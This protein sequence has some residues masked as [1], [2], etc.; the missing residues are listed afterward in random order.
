[1]PRR[2]FVHAGACLFVGWSLLATLVG[3]QGEARNANLDYAPKNVQTIR[4]LQR[5]TV[6]GLKTNP[7]AKAGPEGESGSE[8]AAASDAAQTTEQ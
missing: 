5:L 7:S 1:M 8:N 3:C 4:D 2:L 6:P